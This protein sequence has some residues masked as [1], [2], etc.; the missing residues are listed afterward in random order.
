LSSQD[1]AS[2]GVL[3]SGQSVITRVVRVASGRFAPGHLGE[4]TQIVPFEMVDQALAE[5]GAVQAR[6]RDLPSRVVVYLLL[7]AGLFAEVGYVGVWQRLVSG[8]GGLV[9]ATPTASALCQARRR[10]GVEPLRFLFGLLAGPAVTAGSGG[11]GWRGLLVCAIDGTTMSVPD[12][13]ANLTC[14][15]RQAGTH[16]GSGYPLL[17]LLAVVACG[18]RTVIDAVSAPISIGETSQAPRLLG[19]LRPG[20]LLLADRNFAAAKVITAITDTGAQLLIRCKAN[21]K[22]PVLRR[23]PDGSYLSRWNDTEVRVVEAEITIATKTGRRT[24][25]YRLITTLVD[26]GHYPAM[27]IVELYHQRWEIETA[28]LE[29][30]STILGGRVL[31][32]RTPPGITQEIYAL[33]TTY[34]ALRLA[35]ADATDSQPGT[36]PDRASFT[37]ALH[38]ARDQLVQ[39]AGVIA[40]TTIDLVGAIGRLVLANLLPARRTRTSPRAIKRATSKHNTQGTVN[41]TSYKATI[42]INILTCP[43]P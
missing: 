32:A 15:G 40:E 29:L 35:M 42:H 25:S 38:A 24:G 5:T 41:R 17:R 9:V 14:Y 19:C 10:V 34:Q 2:P 31:R 23:Y 26:P 12:S 11:V 43:D 8:L 28:Y 16:G 36:D 4:L 1:I 13:A 20:M 33:L 3:L 37:T 27:E 7:A 18:T 21:R 39:A 22:L 30:K 6:L